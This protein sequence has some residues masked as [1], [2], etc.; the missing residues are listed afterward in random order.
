[1]Q[2]PRPRGSLSDLQ[3]LP[4][5]TAVQGNQNQPASQECQG[6]EK[7][8]LVT[9]LK[10]RQLA[11]YLNIIVMSLK[12]NMK[13][14]AIFDSP[15]QLRSTQMI[16]ILLLS[17]STLSC[18]LRFLFFS[19]LR[20]C[21]L[22]FLCFCCSLSFMLQ[23]LIPKGLGYFFPEA[24]LESQDWW[25]QEEDD[26]EEPPIRPAAKRGILEREEVIINFH[27]I[28][29]LFHGSVLALVLMEILIRFGDGGINSVVFG[30]QI[31][32]VFEIVQVVHD[33]NFV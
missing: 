14:N 2:N 7:E 15:C 25:D 33:S 27:C 1:M 9:Y 19:Q 22:C 20:C 23:L 24:P 17:F 18:V 4:A 12:Y 6:L 26:D 21:F 3:L 5:H 11:A 30:E 10:M 28:P 8:Q 29:C 32:L 13:T 16:S 31:L